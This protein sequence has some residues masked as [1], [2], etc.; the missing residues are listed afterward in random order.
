MLDGT[1]GGGYRVKGFLALGTVLLLSLTLLRPVG[2]DD[3]GTIVPTL[4]A[5]GIIVTEV[6]DAP[7]GAEQVELFNQGSTTVNMNGWRLVTDGSNV[8]LSALGSFFPLFYRTV[9][10]PTLSNLKVDITLGDEGGYVNVV[11]PSGKVRDSVAYGQ[12]GVAPDPLDSES[13][14]RI[15]FGGV[16]IDSWTRTASS[17]FGFEN[18]A[19]PHANKP[20]LLFNEVLFNSANPNNR[21]IEL[22][23]RGPGT[24]T[25][26]GFTLVGDTVSFL[27]TV[28]LTPT[29]PYHS[30][31]PTDAPS[32]FS[33]MAPDGDNLYLY[34]SAGV[35]YDQV[36]WS[37][38]HTQNMSMARI[39]D[40]NGT[41][42]GY[43]DTSSVA[44]GWVFDLIPTLPLVTI[45]PRQ[46]G[47]GHLGETVGYSLT[48]K[49]LEP[50]S[51]Y[52][53]LEPQ[54]G[55]LGWTM[56]LFKADGVTPLVDS[57]GD[58]DS[59]PDTGLL[60]SGLS[61]TIQAKVTIPPTTQPDDREIGGVKATLAVDPMVGS[62]VTL[63]TSIYPYI[64][65]SSKAVPG[66]IW[67]NNS[68]PGFDPKEA[69]ITLGMKGRGMPEFTAKPQDA[70]L[71]LD[72][73]GSMAENDPSDLRLSA[74]KHYVDLMTIPDRAAVVD[75]D[76]NAILVGGDHLGSDYVR[77]KANID[78]IDAL[79][80]TNLYDPIRISTDELISHGDKTHTLVEILLTDG[81]D[82]TGHSRTQILTQAARAA[83]NNI[84]IFTIGLI[85]TGGV[86]ENLLID[87]ANTTG[88]TYMRATSAS[89]L[90]S[91]YTEI[92]KLVKTSD[93]AGIDDDVKD[94]IP[95]VS[96]FLPDY[97]DYVPGTADPPVSY[98][99]DFFG[100]TNLQ[101]NLSELKI[102]DTWTASFNVTS[103]L[104]GIGLRSTA[105]PDTRVSYIRHD[106]LR[107]NTPFPETFID[108]LAPSVKK[109]KICG[110][111]WSDIDRDGVIDG[112]ESYIAGFKIELYQNGSLLNT[113][114]TNSTGG[115]CF[116]NLGEGNYTVAEVIPPNPNASYDWVQTYPG[117]DGNWAIAAK[118]GNDTMNADFGNVL[119]FTES[120]T[121]GYWKTH[122][123]LNSPPRD[124]AY[125]LLPSNPMKGDL[126]TSDGDYELDS[127]KEALWLFTGSGTGRSPNCSGDCRSLFRAQLLALHMSMLK[128]DGMAGA[129]YIY[130]GDPYSGMTVQQIHDA[131]VAMLTD[132][133]PH[134]FTA[135]QTT[136]DRMNN[137]HNRG[138]GDHVLVIAAPEPPIYP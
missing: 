110:H 133:N 121:W 94:A 99:G 25:M 39:P 71:L 49:N 63:V 134:S 18:K 12:L 8:S 60:P 100:M 28:V 74:A 107:V 13:I 95:M 23:Y 64:D 81:D 69:R 124:K 31:K 120:R 109:C 40:G 61:T 46:G 10:D 128:F 5:S 16:Y 11:D 118:T 136:I 55:P 76:E 44:A 116:E 106:G 66:A 78:T 77:I 98:V 38:L 101:W 135:F 123:G 127:E 51:A 132:G 36:G 22:Y 80:A 35:M 48:V 17:T 70:V 113:T 92:S 72:S 37:S 102:N 57:P 93:L 9:G 138:P 65:T 105:Y 19:A 130:A 1:A 75:F 73:S 43:N 67:V 42:G 29:S 96:A 122:T 20:N 117:G 45:G 56:A 126:P 129:V 7:N 87:I 79:G 54:L 58:P 26:S 41:Y 30:I 90:D 85:G 111:K 112:N 62:S 32:L 104:E 4:T 114:F 84:I 82:T 86:N 131:A 6:R 3:G 21:F 91:I 97:L 15:Y 53:N 52:V 27:P 47:T 89:D 68:P 14:S 137:N 108:V 24:L 125:D 50:T 83:Y 103:S 34:D 2:S 115:Y 59:I 88:G 119:E 33:K